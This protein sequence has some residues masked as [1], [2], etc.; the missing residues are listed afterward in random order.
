MFKRSTFDNFDKSLNEQSVIIIFTSTAKT[1]DY[2]IV[3]RELTSPR[4]GERLM[5]RRE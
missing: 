3:T 5:L 4:E 2:H 1:F